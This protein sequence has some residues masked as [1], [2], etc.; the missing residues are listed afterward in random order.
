VYLGSIRARAA[1]VVSRASVDTLAEQV[2][3]LEAQAEAGLVTPGDVQQLRARLS[4]AKV[5]NVRAAGALR[6]L[7]ES[8]RRVLHEDRTDLRHADDLLS[9][10]AAQL[11]TK[12]AALAEALKSRAEVR[13]LGHVMQARQEQV[14][15]ERAGVFPRLTVDANVVHAKPNQAVFF[16]SQNFNTT[17]TLSINLLWSPNDAVRAWS[18]WGKADRELAGVAAD[19]LALEDA[20]NVEVSEAL[21]TYDSAQR[22]L[23][24]VKDG[25]DAAESAYED[26]KSLVAAGQAPTTELV[27]AEQDLRNAQLQLINVHLD[28]RLARAR[29]DRALGRLRKGDDR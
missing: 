13:A 11:P 14:A 18:A 26:R 1:E 24:A 20:I 9:V 10:A 19:L 17:W 23:A 22:L 25:L 29:L 5:D 3:D 6:V 27:L 21:T 7:E 2:A 4:F 16:D 15:V 28:I 12:D 8:L